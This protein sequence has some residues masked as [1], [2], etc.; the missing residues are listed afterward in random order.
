MKDFLII[1]SASSE[2]TNLLKLHAKKK[3][4]QISRLYLQDLK[5]VNKICHVSLSVN[6][7]LVEIELGERVAAKQWHHQDSYFTN[8]KSRLFF[9]WVLKKM[10]I[11]MFLF[12]L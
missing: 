6:S 1:V 9:I 12:K 10:K 7:T 8:I 5:I 4:H 3:N 11:R 2:R